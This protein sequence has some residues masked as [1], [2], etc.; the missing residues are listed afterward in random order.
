[1]I[2]RAYRDTDLE[3]L[4]ALFRRAVHQGAKRHYSAAERWAWAP[5]RLDRERFG[6]QCQQNFLLLAIA[7]PRTE[8]RILGFGD[9]TESGEIDRLFVHPD[10]HRQGIA[11]AL[12]LALETEARRRGL[13]ELTSNA[14]YLAR[15]FF[16]R[17]GFTA[18]KRQANPRAGQVLVNFKMLKSLSPP[19]PGAS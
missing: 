18:I 10:H 14:S 17:H 11:T 13:V 15:P 2:L 8:D 16:E 7:D 1:M 12:Y 5:R 4:I 19:R 6:R 3:A 9:L